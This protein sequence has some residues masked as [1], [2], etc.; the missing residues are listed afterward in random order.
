[1][2]PLKASRSVLKSWRSLPAA[3]TVSTL[4]G[5]SE[6]VGADVPSD[7]FTADLDTSRSDDLH[8]CLLKPAALALLVMMSR[9]CFSLYGGNPMVVHVNSLNGTFI[10]VPMT[11][12]RG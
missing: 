9:S 10:T 12:M 1:M 6:D 5:I 2:M 3:W 8:L 11:L 7:A 4:V